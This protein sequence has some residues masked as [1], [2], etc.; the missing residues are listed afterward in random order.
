PGKSYVYNSAYGSVLIIGPYNYP[1]QLTIEP[2][3]GAIA[4]GNTTVI[5]PSEYTTNVEYILVKIIKECFNSNYIDIV[6]G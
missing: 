6:V 1:F 5:K 2:L 4:G 3:I